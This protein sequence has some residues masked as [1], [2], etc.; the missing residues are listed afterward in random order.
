MDNTEILAYVRHRMTEMG[1]PIGSYTTSWHDQTL[2]EAGKTTR[3]SDT[4]DI[5]F[6]TNIYSKG[7]VV[8]GAIIADD[9]ADSLNPLFLNRNFSKV[10]I[11][12]GIID[13]YNYDATQNL[14]LEFIKCSPIM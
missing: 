3:I 14:Y 11:Y 8:N 2:V 4:S 13:C 9:N 5:H 12:R 10:A 6:L 1:Y 7:G